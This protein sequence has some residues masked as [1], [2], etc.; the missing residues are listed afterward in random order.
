MKPSEELMLLL[1]LNGFDVLKF[2]LK[3]QLEFEKTGN[4]PVEI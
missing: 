3:K 4:S 1:E 2:K